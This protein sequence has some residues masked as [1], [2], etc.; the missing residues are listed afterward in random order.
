MLILAGPSILL[1]YTF[2]RSILLSDPPRVYRAR[3]IR[4]VP[5]L[6]IFYL[7]LLPLSVDIFLVP[8]ESPFA[9]P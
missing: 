8:P 5:G 3:D 6:Y 9:L 1:P 7:V 4:P 2:Y